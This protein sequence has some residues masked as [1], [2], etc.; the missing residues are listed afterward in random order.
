M[1]Q[2][3]DGKYFQFFVFFLSINKKNEKK[4]KKKNERCSILGLKFVEN[5]ESFYQK[6]C[7]LYEIYIESGKEDEEKK[8]EKMLNNFDFKGKDEKGKL[9]IISFL[10][11]AVFANTFDPTFLNIIKNRMRQIE[12]ID[13]SGT[14]KLLTKES[15]FKLIEECKNLKMINFS[16]CHLIDDDVIKNLNCNGLEILK[17]NESLVSD[18]SIKQKVSS[19]HH[20]NHLDLSCCKYITDV[21]FEKL[22]HSNIQFFFVRSCDKITSKIF[23]FLDTGKKRINNYFL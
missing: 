21:T 1:Q 17:L 4:R 11:S 14:K 16:G 23:S 9:E 7:A 5:D 12:Q 6:S 10:R 2:S 19:F 3:I 13:L 20:L 18:D 8:I 22:Q 15:I